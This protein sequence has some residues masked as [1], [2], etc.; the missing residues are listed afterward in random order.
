MPPLAQVAQRQHRDLAVDEAQ[1][2]PVAAALALDVG[3]CARIDGFGH[4]R[5]QNIQRLCELHRARASLRGCE[6]EGDQL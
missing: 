2:P 3:A 1:L 4:A 6:S 5:D